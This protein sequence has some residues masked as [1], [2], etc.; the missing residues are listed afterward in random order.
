ME[1]KLTA[2]NSEQAGYE[3][4]YPG[5]YAHVKTM[6]YNGLEMSLM[7]NDSSALNSDH[8]RVPRETITPTESR[9]IT[10]PFVKP[11]G[12]TIPTPQGDE[13]HSEGLHGGKNTIT[14]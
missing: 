14:Y 3:G 9:G 8:N 10:G 2:K 5:T 11:D 7:G 13:K 12:Q 6:K 4:E 1:D